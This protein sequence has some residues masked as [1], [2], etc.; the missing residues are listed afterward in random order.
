MT[1]G[2][3]QSGHQCYQKVTA[4]LR[5]HVALIGIVAS[6]IGIASGTKMVFKHNDF[7]YFLIAV[8][9]LILVA[10]LGRT[11]TNQARS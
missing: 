5:K 3:L 1:S 10:W 6:V 9:A 11:L 8:W 4:F 7:G 2:E